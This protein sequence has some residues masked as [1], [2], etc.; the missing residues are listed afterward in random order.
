MVSS[1]KNFIVN[2]LLWKKSIKIELEF[3]GVI[4]KKPCEISF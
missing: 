2:V 3:P 1:R 4:N